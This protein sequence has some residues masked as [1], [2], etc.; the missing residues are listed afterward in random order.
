MKLKFFPMPENIE[1]LSE[2]ITYVVIDS[3]ERYHLA[4]FDGAELEIVQSDDIEEEV[5]VQFLA[6]LP[7]A[8]DVVSEFP[9]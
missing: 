3:K 7:A 2:D 4:T 6:A 9:F 5:E 8:E 1:L